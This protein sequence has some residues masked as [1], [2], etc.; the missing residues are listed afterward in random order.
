MHD[1]VNT[2]PFDPARRLHAKVKAAAFERGLLVYPM[3]GT[4]DGCYGD[5]ILLAPP[6]ITSEAELEQIVDRVTAAVDAA[7]AQ[8]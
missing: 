2:S 4:L 7:I 6:S 5:H 3:G 8:G 1:R